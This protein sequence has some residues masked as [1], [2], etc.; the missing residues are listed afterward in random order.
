[1][2]P[3]NGLVIGAP[4]AWRSPMLVHRNATLFSMKVL[5]LA[6]TP[7]E[8][9]ALAPGLEAAGAQVVGTTD[10][11]QLVRSAIRHAPE[12]VVA[13]LPEVPPPMFE[14][15]RLL[16]ETAPCAVLVVTDDESPA[17]MEQAVRLGVGAW[18]VRG[19]PAA[20]WAPLMALAQRRHAW[21][22]AQQAEM[23]RLRAQLDERKWVDRAKGLLMRD[24]ALSEEQAF[25]LLRTASMHANLRV[26]EVSRG[27]IEAAQSAGAINRSGLL[28]MLS[29]RIARA[30]LQ[31][32]LGLEVHVARET[33]AQSRER[34][35]SAFAH[36]LALPLGEALG[37][38][39][40][41]ALQAWEALKPLLDDES[42][43][44]SELDA[45]AE[46][47]L[48][49]ADRLTRALEDASGR[50]SLQMVN[51]CGRQ[52][53]LAQRLAKQAL[54]VAAGV[55]SPVQAPGALAHTMHEFEQALETL[56]QAPASGEGLRA[57]LAAARAHWVRLC[58]GTRAAHTRA[59]GLAV[60]RE[61]EALVEEFDHLTERYERSMQ[62]LMA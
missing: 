31:L 36:L 21:L 41:Q 24:N 16:A 19:A 1:M 20:R 50:R 13:S 30:R 58:D 48:D 2:T 10:G 26:G 6:S 59:G 62:V 32:R 9:L 56:E 45:R 55:D 33:L 29:Q 11:H 12:L 53:M 44:L 38:L 52:R 27:V 5:I 17:W 42:V 14:A 35:D 37:T 3:C 39:R 43:P 8:A 25:Q 18:V 46:A 61:S 54:M 4:A 34:A 23:A 28:R 49:G 22:R 40:A 51:L 7:D 47:L 60:A 57:G 15:L